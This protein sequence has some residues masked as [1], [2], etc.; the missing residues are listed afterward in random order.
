MDTMFSFQK[1][2]CLYFVQELVMFYTSIISFM[3]GNKKRGDVMYG[4]KHCGYSL[5]IHIANMAS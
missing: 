3:T 1:L 2:Y 5:N 4:T